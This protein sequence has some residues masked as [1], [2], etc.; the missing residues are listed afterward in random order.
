MHNYVR[1]NLQLDE[2]ILIT[3]K[4]HWAI[5]LDAYLQLSVS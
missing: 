4:L 2:D 1:N 3:P 5:Y